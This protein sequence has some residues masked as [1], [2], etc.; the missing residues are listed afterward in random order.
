MDGPFTFAVGD[1]LAHH[2]DRRPITFS[3]ELGI[4]SEYARLIGPVSGSGLLEGVPNGVY[5]A[6]EGETPVEYI[7]NRCLQPFQSICRLSFTQ[8]F[9]GDLDEDGYKIDNDRID[10]EPL[11]RDEVTLSLPL[12]PL[13]R[14]D[15]KGLCATCGTDLNTDPCTGHAESEA[16]PFAALKDIIS[17]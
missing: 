9:A 6:V 16:S 7:C 8:V 4:Q 1:L 11:L 15:C 13:C 2:G 14:P 5:A 12:V 10:L 17:D 3:G